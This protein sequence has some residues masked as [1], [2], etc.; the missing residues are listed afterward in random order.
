M[1]QQ[2]R[3]NEFDD[4]VEA[5]A[6]FSIKPK[7]VTGKRSSAFGLPTRTSVQVDPFQEGKRPFSLLARLPHHSAYSVNQLRSYH[8]SVTRGVEQVAVAESS[9]SVSLPPL[10]FVDGKVQ[11]PVNQNGIRAKLRVW[12]EENGHLDRLND[13]PEIVDDPDT[14]EISTNLTRLPNNTDRIVET[15]ADQRDTEEETMAHF[16]YAAVEGAN[17]SEHNPRYLY[18]GDF[19]ELNVRR[20]DSSS[21]PAVFVRRIGKTTAQLY[22]MNGRWV[23]IPEKQVQFAISGWASQE[24]IEPLLQYLPDP[25]SEQEL[26]DLDEDARIY[27]LS[28]P[29]EI[30][31]PLI[32]RMVEFNAATK[33]IYRI[34]ARALDDA[35]AILRWPTDLRMMKLTK[36]ASILL[37]KR[38]SQLTVVD[39]FAVRQALTKAGFAF[40]FD[41]RSHRLTGHLH[42]RSKEQVRVVET[43]QGWLREWQ[44]DVAAVASLSEGQKRKHKAS[45]GASIVYSF[46]RK[47]QG[48]VAKSREDREPTNLFQVGPSK[49]R[50]PITPEQDCVRISKDKSFSKHDTDILRFLEGWALST[51]FVGQPSLE[52]LPPLLLG[53]TGLYEGQAL[54]APVGCLFLQEVGTI[55][56]YDNRVRF[57]QHLLLPHAESSKAL[58]NLM[59][60]LMEY[61]HNGQ[62]GLR[63]C[64]ADLRQDWG[65]LPVYCIDDASAHEIDDGIS[66]EPANTSTDGVQEWWVR[67]HI[68]NPTAF[69]DRKS[70]FAMMAEHLGESIYL[71]ERAYMML[72]RW[73]TQKYFSLAPN[74]S[75]LTFSARVNVK[76]EILENDIRP[77]IVRNVLRLTRDEVT[78][79][80]GSSGKPA[81]G[82]GDEVVLTVGGEAQSPYSKRVSRLGDLTSDMKEQLHTLLQIAQHRASGRQANGGL[83]F[84]VHKPDVNVWQNSRSNGLAWEPPW[85]EGARHVEGD[86]VIQVRTRPFMNWFSPHIEP[87][88]LLV[89]ENMLLACAVGA[90]WCEARAIP[91]IFRG[92][93]KAPDEVDSDVYFR[94][95]VLPATDET[96]E[97]P[98][99]IGMEYL[100]SFGHTALSTRP[101]KHRILGMDKYGKV[102]SPLRRYGDL[103][104]HWQIEAAIREESRTGKSLITPSYDGVSRD[105]FLPFTESQLQNANIRLQPRESLIMK[106]KYNG[107]QYWICL[108]LFRALHFNEIDLPLRTTEDGKKICTAFV[109]N[110]AGVHATQ[111]PCILME[112]NFSATMLRDAVPGQRLVFRPGDQWE[113]ELESVDCYKRSIYLRPRR[114]LERIE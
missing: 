47:V 62:H 82:L 114:L 17:S 2:A 94:E 97:Y 49:V 59:T 65:S 56:P 35:H 77:G 104:M 16:T 21:T 63:D 11:K 51:I 18:M 31:A 67:V 76:G 34:H 64:M 15:P 79:V 26:E 57:D 92:S 3:Q 74:R 25:K 19:V 83:F 70:P 84:D 75:C 44:D 45:K 69:F 88:E 101:I 7:I 52:S 29:R 93:V 9:P 106:S 39:L 42:I 99:T 81:N 1:L 4:A 13:V 32:K 50:I 53:A 91:A 80:L 113:C 105:Y 20:S 108:L 96:G 60:Q 66:I 58:E 46:I 14:G 112:F 95:H 40:N 89:R 68:A 37:E 38:I 100:S 103:V 6:A 10:T 30:S 5:L 27:D 107:E 54:G 43:V 22:T 12:Q 90:T 8:S 23:H 24:E 102:T 109:H 78:E 72:P 28:V 33:E 73:A 111:V 48:V 86:P 61:R 85:R 98:M 55:L 36:A 71:P 110:I 41:R 87:V